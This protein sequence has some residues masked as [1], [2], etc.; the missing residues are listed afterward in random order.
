[1]RPMSILAHDWSLSAAPLNCV[2]C[3]LWPTLC[4]LNG[5][6]LLKIKQTCHQLAYSLGVAQ[7]QSMAAA[8]TAINLSQGAAQR[9]EYSP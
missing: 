9:T 2:G 3:S 5:F 4:S 6:V 8:S 7:F 1:V